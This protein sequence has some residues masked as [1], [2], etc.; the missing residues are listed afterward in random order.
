M[1]E[2]SRA[3]YRESRRETFA[4]GLLELMM[5]MPYEKIV[6]RD[7]CAHVQISRKTFYRYFS[8]KEEVLCALIDQLLINIG[9]YMPPAAQN[10][11]TPWLEEMRR[12]FC[13]WQEKRHVLQMLLDNSLIELFFFRAVAVALSE[14]DI[15]KKD[16]QHMKDPNTR[17]S[18][19]SYYVGGLMTML[20]FWMKSDFADSPEDMAQRLIQIN[21]GQ[22][23]TQEL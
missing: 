19:V 20:L 17:E 8:N 23:K 6:I 22:T 7:L 2:N 13:Y 12:F 9:T 14:M 18:V 4:S 11:D 21:M 16:A 5:K 3:D 10:A 1:G 15:F